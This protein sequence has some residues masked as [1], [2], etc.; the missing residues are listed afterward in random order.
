M[1]LR[2]SPRGDPLELPGLDYALEGQDAVI[3]AAHGPA[4]TTTA[5]YTMIGA[6]SI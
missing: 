6:K 3:D 1:G 2:G 4:T 5:I